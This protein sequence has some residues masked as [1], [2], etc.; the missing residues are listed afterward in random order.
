VPKNHHDTLKHEIEGQVSLGVLKRCSDS[1]WEAPKFIIPKKNGTVRFMSDF[2]KLN[3]QLKRKPYPIPKNAQM[4]Q[5]LEEFAYATSLDLNMGYYST[6]FDP[7][8]QKLCTIVIPFGKYQEVRFTMGISCSPD[9]FQE[10]MPNLM[11]NLNF[12]RTYLDDILV[13]SCSTFE[14]H[15]LEKIEW[16]LKILSDKGLRVN[17]EK[18]T[19]VLMKLSTS[20]TGS[21]SQVYNLSLKR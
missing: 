8:A 19:F 14:D 16:V 18:S 15:F 11:Q 21:V 6:R 1:E 7:D 4:L 12:V 13:I 5:E 10:N 9:I 17:A 3:E 20:G 2:R